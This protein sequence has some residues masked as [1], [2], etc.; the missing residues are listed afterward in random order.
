MGAETFD[1]EVGLHGNVKEGR[2]PWSA[3]MAMSKLKHN[4]QSGTVQ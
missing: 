3:V 4:L 2:G 1:I